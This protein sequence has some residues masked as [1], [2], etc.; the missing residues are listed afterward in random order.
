MGHLLWHGTSKEAAEAIVLNDFVIPEGR[1]THGTRFGKGA[2]FA[3]DL[4]KSLSYAPIDGDGRQ[5]V[6]LCRVLCGDMYYTEVG[7]LPGAVDL[8]RQA[9]KDSVLANPD[10]RGPRE[11]IM[12]T[13]DQ[14]YPE[15]ILELSM[16]DRE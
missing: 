8:A 1:A 13:T 14:V 12:P 9:G 11:F 2:Y 6:L 16:K 5:W 4:E 15:H 3:E 10:A 7:S